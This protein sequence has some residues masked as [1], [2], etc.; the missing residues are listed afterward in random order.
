MD[1]HLLESLLPGGSTGQILK[2][3]ELSSLFSISHIWSMGNTHP[4]SHQI[5]GVQDF[6]QLSSP[7]LIPPSKWPVILFLSF[8][9]S[10]CKSA[11]RPQLYVPTCCSLHVAKWKPCHLARNEGGG[12]LYHQL[13]IFQQLTHTPLSKKVQELKVLFK[14]SQNTHANQKRQGLSILRSLCILSTQL[15]QGQEESLIQL[16][17]T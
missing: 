8:Q 12:S 4:L 9:I 2:G 7:L 17:G 10:Q 3:L 6:P 13:P 14:E 5:K 11:F 1:S 15:F 16:L